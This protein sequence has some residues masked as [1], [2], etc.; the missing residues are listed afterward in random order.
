MAFKDIFQF[1]G[2]KK[3]KI[4]TGIGLFPDVGGSLFLPRLDG[5]LGMFLALT[6]HRLKGKDLVYCGIATHYVPSSR[7]PELEH[8]LSSNTF[9]SLQ[10][11]DQLIHDYSEDFSLHFSFLSFFY[12]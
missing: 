11:I 10:W 5:E 12:F 2:K 6:G 1:F 3:I 8:H 4:E 9:E 7:L